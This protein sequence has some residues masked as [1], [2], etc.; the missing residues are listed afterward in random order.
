M[1]EKNIENTENTQNSV[2]ENKELSTAEKLLLKIKQR[3][4]PNFKENEVKAKEEAKEEV[5]KETEK[6]TEEVVEETSDTVNS[7]DEMDNAKAEIVEEVAE[8]LT[9]EKEEKEDLKEELVNYFEKTKEELVDIFTNLLTVDNT[10]KYKNKVKE[11]RNAFYNIINKEEEERK[12]K[13]VEDG[14]KLEDYEPIKDAIENKFKELYQ[15]FIDKKETWELKLKEEK[16]KNLELKYEVI[17]EI[18]ELINKPETFNKTFNKFKE[19]QKKWNEIGLVPKDAV[20]KLLEEYNRQV[21]KFYEYVEVNKQLR[22]L[23]FKKNLDA[24]IKLCEQA[25]ELLLE[26]NYSKA[27]KQLQVLHKKWKELGAVA[28]EHREEIWARF[29]AATIKINEKFSKY[30]EEVKAQQEKNLEAK[31]FLVQKAQEYASGEYSDHK[32]WKE[33]SNQII[34]LQKLWR[35]IGYVPKEHNNE[36]YTK[37][38]TACDNFFARIREFYDESDKHRDDN[39]QKKLDLCTQAESLQN[40]NE[41]NTTTEIYKQIQ[42]DWKKIGPVPRKY[43]DEIWKRFRKACNT[44]F[45]RKKEHFM[46]KKNEEKQNL[47]LKQ[48]I[49]RKIQE[50][51]FSDN[52]M[53]DL[54]ALKEL[55]NQFM[56]VGYVPFKNKD[57]IYEQF[58]NAIDTQL[59][60]LNVTRE[61]QNELKFTENLEYIKNSPNSDKLVYNEISKIQHQIDKLNDDIK[62]WENNIGFF[63]SSKNSESMIKNIKDKIEAAKNKVA[64]FKEQIE[65]LA[66]INE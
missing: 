61:K 54:K 38:K 17:K 10:N 40:S 32:E 47:E 59:G 36:I 45:D 60:K 9:D 26:S 21:H 1:S 27:K 22:E 41:W 66:K 14:S 46:G 51:E 18:Q 6:I 48:E 5:K 42:E 56:A 3:Q 57:E 39:Y 34:E 64:K 25:E 2:N 52:Q 35:K 33:A 55:Q 53:E 65:E 43:S 62:V 29:Q 8:N 19:L 23:D 12:A 4:D 11:I 28:N 24:K 31:Q 50:F 7:E 16:K 30:I 49:I 44:F 63:A 20:K 13:F 15:K 37:F 58:H